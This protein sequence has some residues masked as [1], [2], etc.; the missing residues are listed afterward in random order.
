MKPPALSILNFSE[1]ISGLW[2]LVK[3]IVSLPFFKDPIALESPKFAKYPLLSIK[4]KTIPQEPALSGLGNNFKD[5]SINKFS[6]IA[7]PSSIAF[8]GSLGKNED[9]IINKCNFSFKKSAQE[10]PPWPSKIPK[11]EQVG[12]FSP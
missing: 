4:I 1:I 3:F 5:F 11:Y 2:S 10:L 6:A 7:N 9:P 8:T 12:H